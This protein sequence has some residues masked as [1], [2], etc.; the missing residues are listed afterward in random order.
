M[1]QRYRNLLLQSRLNS[2]KD[3]AHLGFCRLLINRRQ[4]DI[5]D[6]FSMGLGRQG[7]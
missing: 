4:D 5:V 7:N 1:H 3:V 2:A 6:G